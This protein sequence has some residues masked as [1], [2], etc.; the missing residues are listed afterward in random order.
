ML[1]LSLTY[2]ESAALMKVLVRVVCGEMNVDE[3][4]ERVCVRTLKMLNI[5]VV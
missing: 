2:E 3:Q 5:E 1:Q 4:T